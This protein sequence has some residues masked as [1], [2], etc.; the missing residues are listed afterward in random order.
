MKLGQTDFLRMKRA[1]EKITMLTAYDALTGRMVEASDMD[2]ILVGDSLGMT[3]LGYSTT[4]QV[5]LGEMLHHA[6]A[7]ARGVQTIH[8]IGDMPIGTYEDPELAVINAK[9]FI[10]VGCDSVK[11]EGCRV[12]VAQALRKQNIQAVGHLGLT[13]QTADKFKVHGKDQAD[14]ERIIEESERLDK[15]NLLLLI[16]ECVP[17][18]L[19]REIT[20]RIQTP[21]ISIG[22][23]PDCNGQVLVSND[24]LGLFDKFKPRFVRRYANLFDD[25]VAAMKRFRTDVKTG[26]YPSQEESY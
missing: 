3:A 14:A 5:T 20:R 12:D 21:T 13:P 15:E 25:A 26:H 10:K 9:K 2:V 22:A 23:G 6:K 16:L 8:I 24:L 4:K 1:G 11:F 19:G 7:V 18:W 17:A